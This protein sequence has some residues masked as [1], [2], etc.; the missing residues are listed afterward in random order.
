MP[1]P[2]EE[3]DKKES[4]RLAKL[5][6]KGTKELDECIQSK[7]QDSPIID[8]VALLANTGRLHLFYETVGKARLEGHSWRAISSAANGGIEYKDGQRMNFVYRSFCK[9]NG[10]EPVKI[11]G[12]K[13]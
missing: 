3:I 2:A 9:N 11:R 13:S 6:D 1:F 4:E 12:N 5:R 10:I 8:Q 7:I